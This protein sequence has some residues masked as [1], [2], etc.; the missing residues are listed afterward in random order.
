MDFITK[1]WSLIAE[2]V[3]VK[4]VV[5]LQDDLKYDKI[6]KP[7]WA[8]LKIFWSDAGKII[9]AGKAWQ[10][11]LWADNILIVY[12]QDQ[13]RILQVDQYEIQ[14]QGIDTK[15]VNVEGDTIIR[16]DTQINQD[17]QHEWLVREIC[18]LLNQMRKDADYQINQRLSCHIACQDTNVLD[19]L[20]RYE[21]T[22]MS[23]ALLDHIDYGTQVSSW[24]ITQSRDAWSATIYFT[25]QNL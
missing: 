3:N 19:L 12:D 4:H 6:Y 5:V 8:K 17:L 10:V 24:D 9:S 13:E 20:N 1:Y 25:L 2:E 18:R 11:K 7:I 14:Y 15:T 23:E 22:L 21:E 16:L